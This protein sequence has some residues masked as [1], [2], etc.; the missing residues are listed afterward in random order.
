MAQIGGAT[1]HVDQGHAE[2]LVVMAQGAL[3]RGQLLQDGVRHDESTP[4]D[5]GNN[6]LSSRGRA[7]D[8]MA[9]HF[10][11]GAQQPQRIADTVLTVDHKFLGKHMDDF[12][13]RGQRHRPGRLQNSANIG[14][15]DFAALGHDGD[16]SLAVEALNVTPGK[17]HEHRFYVSS[18]TAFRL[19]HRLLDGRDSP[20]QMDD[21]PPAQTLGF[22]RSDSCHFQATLIFDLADDGAGFGGADVQ[23]NHISSLEGQADLQLPGMNPVSVAASAELSRPKELSERRLGQDWGPGF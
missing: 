20:I 19:L 13:V 23:A 21:H 22:G 18:R 14:F 2:L 11:S 7:G 16:R 5:G 3:A 10:Q 8:N 15:A 12:T 17:P 6:I 4:V 1:A 9:I